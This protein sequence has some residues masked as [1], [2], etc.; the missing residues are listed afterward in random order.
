MALLAQRGHLDLALQGRQ[1]LGVRQVYLALLA[2]PEQMDQMAQL[3]LQAQRLL[4]PVQQVHLLLARPA[5]LVQLLVWLAQQA[6][7]A[8]LVLQARLVR[9]L[10]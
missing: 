9:P 4:C 3:A 6:L 7:V 10:Q 8:L 2:P 5:Q 1:V